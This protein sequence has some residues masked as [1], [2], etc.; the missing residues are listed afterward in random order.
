MAGTKGRA[1][2][3]APRRQAQSGHA[4]GG[5]K[6]KARLALGALLALNLLA[7]LMLL[8]PFGGSPEGLEASQRRLESQLQQQRLRLRHAKLLAGKMQS[9]GT[10]GDQFIR[11]HFLDERQAAG[12]LL[13]ALDTIE[14][15]AGI[16]SKGKN[17]T[18]DAIEGTSEYQ[19]LTIDAGYE[20]TFADLV[21]FVNEVD[22]SERLLILDSLQVTPARDEATLQIQAKLFAFVKQSN[23]VA[24][25]Q[26]VTP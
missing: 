1:T 13:K 18:V 6:R 4:A 3:A 12:D 25:A 14:A 22:R 16:R 20:G 2:P 11:A 19:M 10:E 7:A 21:Q 5:P 23:L 9:G 24:S 17:F 15:G 8:E 26:G